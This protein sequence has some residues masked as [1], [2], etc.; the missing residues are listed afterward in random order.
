M[1]TSKVNRIYAVAPDAAGKISL[2][3]VW[4]QSAGPGLG[5]GYSSLVPMQVGERVIL[6]G[7]NKTK[8]AT[9]T[10]GLNAGDP[11]IQPLDSR[12]DLTGGPWDIVQT[13]V[14]GND[15]YLMTY[16]ADHGQFG[17]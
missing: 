9:T 13:F 10:F 8:Q 6:V 11:W 15:R 5:A 2:Q 7:Y 14:F 16:R 3:Q 12:I 17:I 4:A 1:A